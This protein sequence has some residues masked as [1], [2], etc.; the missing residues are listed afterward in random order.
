MSPFISPRNLF[1]PPYGP[2]VINPVLPISLTS[3]LVSTYY[4]LDIVSSYSRGVF[5]LVNYSR[6][7]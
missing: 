1:L 4:V 6:A 7:L 2:Q 5:Y 3:F